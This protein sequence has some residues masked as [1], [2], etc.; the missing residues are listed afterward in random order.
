MPGVVMK[1]VWKYNKAWTSTKGLTKAGD[2]GSA[3]RIARQCGFLPSWV[4]LPGIRSK[5]LRW[6]CWFAGE[7]GCSA[8]LLDRFDGGSGVQRSQACD[9]GSSA[10]G[11]KPRGGWLT[12]GRKM[13]GSGEVSYRWKSRSGR[14]EH[15]WEWGKLEFVS[16][17]VAVFWATSGSKVWFWEWVVE[18]KII[19]IKG[20]KENTCKEF[21]VCYKRPINRGK[22]CC[23]REREGVSNCTGEEARTCF[24]KV[25]IC[26]IWSLREISRS[27]L[28]IQGVILAKHSCAA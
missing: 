14:T 20:W 17:E 11:E 13:G 2:L 3:R 18:V 10:T 21:K 12:L 19:G 4:H 9:F 16:L 24:T 1:G 28:G 7:I 27:S 15:E 23:N 8:G 5:G 26:L 22:R 25:L 6:E